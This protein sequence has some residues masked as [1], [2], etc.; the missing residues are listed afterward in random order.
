V[1]EFEQY[2]KTH[3]VS[4]KKPQIDQRKLEYPEVRQNKANVSKAFF[5]STFATNAFNA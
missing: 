5:I 2:F 1:W 4:I 3:L